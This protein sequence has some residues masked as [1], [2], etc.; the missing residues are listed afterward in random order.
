MTHAE[1]GRLETERM[2][3]DNARQ[4]F[5]A[6]KIG[7][8]QTA[9]RTIAATIHQLLREEP[10]PIEEIPPAVLDRCFDD[11]IRALDLEETDNSWEDQ[12]LALQALF[13]SQPEHDALHTDNIP[14]VLLPTVVPQAEPKSPTTNTLSSG[15]DVSVDTILP[16]SDLPAESRDLPD[17][18]ILPNPTANSEDNSVPQ[19][20]RSLPLTQVS[21]PRASTTPNPS[22]K[23]RLHT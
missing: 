18:I 17:C 1:V 14:P 4:T 5:E 6:N 21:P 2:E 3:L 15:Q 19:P 20:P 23:S 10:T 22:T 11:V 13:Q 16:S 7:W 12:D 8:L 9:V